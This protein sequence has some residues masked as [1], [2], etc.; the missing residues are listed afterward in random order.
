MSI[1]PMRLNDEH[2]GLGDTIRAQ[3]KEN[4][5]ARGSYALSITI[6]EKQNIRAQPG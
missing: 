4:L 1:N 5:Q 2:E 6:C 3:R